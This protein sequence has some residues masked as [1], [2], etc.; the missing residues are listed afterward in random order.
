M[1]K[2]AFSVFVFGSYERFLPYYVFSITKNYPDVAILIFYNTVLSTKVKEYL[3]SFTEV[4]LFENFYEEYNF[5]SKFTMKGGG[6]MTLL[7][8]LIPGNYFSEYDNLYFGD[9]DIV[10]LKEN[11]DLFEFHTLQAKKSGV[12]FSNRVRYKANEELSKRL[13][14]LH[15]VKVKPYYRVMDPI[16]NKILEDQSYREQILNSVVRDEEF[17]Y[18][19][20]KLAF[21][22][23]PKAMAENIVPIHGI[24]L[25]GFRHSSVPLNNPIATPGL[26]VHKETVQKQLNFF[27]Q[28]KA[29][30]KILRTFY[31]KEMLR[32]LHYF[33]VRL[34]KSM[35]LI[36][37]FQ[38]TIAYALKRLRIK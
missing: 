10:I 21:D 4:K 32:A 26:Y 13:T 36:L 35:V 16:I 11:F 20:N 28:D 30:L 33:E 5:F 2:N 1:T 8:Y 38:N 34:P 9:V 18:T 24:H 6:G 25:G 17:L 29:F 31:C 37:T 12:P 27:V 14:G 15:F 7:R 22:F 23:N 19:L 3:T